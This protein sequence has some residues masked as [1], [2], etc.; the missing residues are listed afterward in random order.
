MIL[1]LDDVIDRG[2]PAPFIAVRFF[3]VLKNAGDCFESTGELFPHPSLSPH[4]CGRVVSGRDP[5]GAEQSFE[6]AWIDEHAA[7]EF[8]IR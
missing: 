5:G 8:Q 6:V 1:G 7:A 4:V 2:T 3:A